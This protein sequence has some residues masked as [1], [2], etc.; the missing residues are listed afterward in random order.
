[1]LYE[2]ALCHAVNL[3]SK[4]AAQSIVRDTPEEVTKWINSVALKLWKQ[5]KELPWLT[6]DTGQKDQ[7]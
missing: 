6:K 3:Y 1:M 2:E 7:A 4:H 5:Y